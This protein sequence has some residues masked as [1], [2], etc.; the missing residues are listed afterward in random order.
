MDWNMDD[1]YGFESNADNIISDELFYE[2]TGD[3]NLTEH[4]AMPFQQDN[5]NVEESEI[6]GDLESVLGNQIEGLSDAEAAEMQEFWG[7]LI[8]GVASA[9]PAIVQGVGSLVNKRKRRRR[10]RTPQPRRPVA[11][12]TRPSTPAPRT[13]APQQPTRRN[14]SHC[15]PRRRSTAGNVRRAGGRAL[16]TLGSILSNPQ[17]QGLLTNVV[18]RM[19]NR[20]SGYEEQIS[21][22]AM[23]NAIEQ[24]ARLAKQEVAPA[25]DNMEY[26]KDENGDFMVDIASPEER[27]YAVAELLM[28]DY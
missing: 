21:D 9:L 14:I 6:F 18:G 5:Y 15:Q 28:T 8:T 11:R 25:N 22:A 24:L 19:A 20:G 17:V 13:A 10:R 3:A 2:I 26:L 23:L 1:E 27:A 7:A 4:G 16:Q 12:T